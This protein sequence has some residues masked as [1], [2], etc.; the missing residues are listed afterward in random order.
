MTQRHVLTVDFKDIKALEVAC[1]CGGKFTIPVPKD[2]L[3]GNVEC[4][5]CNKRLWDGGDDREFQIVKGLLVMLGQV[6]RR[7]DKIFRLGFSLDMPETVTP[8]TSEIRIA[9]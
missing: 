4:V 2:T 7:D 9:P 3:P 8:N 6:Q 1:A 5:G